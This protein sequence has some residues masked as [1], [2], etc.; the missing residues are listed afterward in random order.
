VI[1]DGWEL[2]VNKNVTLVHSAT[3]AVPSVD[4]PTVDHVILVLVNVDADLDGSDLIATNLARKVTTD[5]NAKKNA[6][7]RML[8]DV[9]TSPASVCALPAGEDPSARKHA[10]QDDMVNV[11]IINVHVSM[12]YHVTT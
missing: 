9:I 6:T 2:R 1:L 11:A 7:A 12:E 4:V 5:I 10:W 3:V 8:M